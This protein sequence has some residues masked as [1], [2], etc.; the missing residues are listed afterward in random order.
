MIRLE[1]FLQIFGQHKTILEFF[2]FFF[3]EYIGLFL[4][5]DMVQKVFLGNLVLKIRHE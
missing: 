4:P 5:K 2:S 3:K 1:L